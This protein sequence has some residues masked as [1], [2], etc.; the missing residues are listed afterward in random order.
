M[1]DPTT[2]AKDSLKPSRRCKWTFVISSSSFNRSKTQGIDYGGRSDATLDAAAIPKAS[3]AISKTD[4]S[5]MQTANH[6]EVREC[7]C[8]A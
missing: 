3:T 2:I 7:A 4:A 8:R 1:M 5:A 6:H